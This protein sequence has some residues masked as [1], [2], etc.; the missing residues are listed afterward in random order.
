[1]HILHM[2]LLPYIDG[3]SARLMRSAVIGTIESRRSQLARRL[4][5]IQD[6]QFET[7]KPG[8]SASDVDAVARK[9]IL[10]DGLRP[11]YPNITGYSS[12]AIRHRRRAPATSRASSC[13]RPT[14]RSKKAWCSTCTSPPTGSRSARPFWSRR[15]DTSV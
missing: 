2:E 13:R 3:Y 5:E 4:I 9:A 15:P 6:R 7:I 8:A 1:M 14:E 12:A 11:D 10:A